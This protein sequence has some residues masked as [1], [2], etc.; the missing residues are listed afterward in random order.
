[1][2]ADFP[3]L[4]VEDDT[5]TLIGELKQL[6][7]W[8][9]CGQLLAPRVDHAELE[10]YIRALE[11]A[12]PP[13]FVRRSVKEALACLDHV[14]PRYALLDLTL[15]DPE[16]QGEDE[17][18]GRII[19]RA[20]QKRAPNCR[21]VAY[22]GAR[23]ERR[24][25]VD[26]DFHR[27]LSK[28]EQAPTGQ[29]LRPY[30]QDLLQEMARTLL[31][32]G[33]AQDLDQRARALRRGL[34]RGE[35]D[36]VR[37]AALASSLGRV[38][39]LPVAN[40][41]SR[42]GTEPHA[43]V[44][45]LLVGLRLVVDLA[46]AV[47]LGE[48]GHWVESRTQELV[49]PEGPF[50]QLRQA[51]SE[52]ELSYARARLDRVLRDLPAPLRR[53]GLG[54][55]LLVL[56]SELESG[57]LKPPAHQERLDQFTEE[58]MAVQ[59][60]PA[61]VDSVGSSDLRPPLK[62]KM[63]NTVSSPPPPGL[64]I[65]DTVTR[66]KAE[67]ALKQHALAAKRDP[68]HAAVL[69][70][71]AWNA[72]E[73]GERPR[74]D[75]ISLQGSELADWELHL[76]E[77]PASPTDPLP[78]YLRHRVVWLIDDHAAIWTPV[79]RRIFGRDCTLRAFPDL[80]SACDELERA[81]DLLLLDLYL[82]LI[83]ERRFPPDV[84][85]RWLNREGR[86]PSAAQHDPRPE[87]AIIGLNLMRDKLP[88]VPVVVYTRSREARRARDCIGRHGAATYAFKNA[89]EETEQAREERALAA[90]QDLK[91]GVVEALRQGVAWRLGF[92]R[93]RRSPSDPRAV[94]VASWCEQFDPIDRSVVMEMLS[95]WQAVDDEGLREHCAA[96]LRPFLEHPDWFAD[97]QQASKVVIVGASRPGKSASPMFYQ[98]WHLPGFVDLRQ[99][100][101]MVDL[102][103]ACGRRRQNGKVKRVKQDGGNP[104]RSRR[105][106]LLVDDFVGTGNTIRKARLRLE[107]YVKDELP[108]G[109]PLQWGLLV[110]G[111]LAEPLDELR[112]QFGLVGAGQPDLP[113]ADAELRAALE[114]CHERLRVRYGRVVLGRIA[115]VRGDLVAIPDPDGPALKPGDILYAEAGDR[116]FEGRLPKARVGSPL[117]TGWRLARLPGQ[118]PVAAAL[119]EADG[120]LRFVVDTC[121]TNDRRQYEPLGFKN[122]SA[123]V[124]FSYNT[125]NNAPAIVWGACNGWRPLLPRN[126]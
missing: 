91:Q 107:Q 115:S 104:L 96:A 31:D 28:G 57:T 24:D 66:R 113:R 26:N 16:T 2:S 49:D 111:G 71:G 60:S 87:H 124:S 105:R 12:S 125:P 30:V 83:A 99:R 20:L 5:N 95:H 61:G 50:G 108:P 1:M 27:V 17:A 106:V 94:D 4:L 32:Q 58:W 64:P 93:A 10:R 85:R 68:W 74:H 97:P 37:L 77:Q 29:R 18:G 23:A 81:P 63:P 100:V 13:V 98:L 3:I 9:V 70:A 44:R 116:P 123:L 54:A 55:A 69:L 39:F 7:Q 79:L 35:R 109:E 72:G 43:R 80:A 117:H 122:T 114:A 59:S 88:L 84:L 8:G 78:P 33:R 40:L 41:A 15:H 121:V 22:T 25:Q 47:Q 126:S 90:F 86:G 14:T 102:D 52:E 65:P 62:P 101:A 21:R 103:R 6:G 51:E 73:L 34:S 48:K 118:R 45:K 120:D 42:A 38:P 67:Q 112:E 11:R 53:D 119:A 82:P 56:L 110:A 92:S 36:P 89:P 76:D 46:V 75:Q 19:A